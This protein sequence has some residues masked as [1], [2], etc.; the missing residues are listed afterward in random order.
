MIKTTRTTRRRLLRA[1]RD[2]ALVSVGLPLLGI[3]VPIVL[4][5]IEELAAIVFGGRPERLLTPQGAGAHQAGFL[6][7]VSI[8]IPAYRE[9]PEML[10]ETLDA[11]SRLD[12]ANFECIVILKIFCNF[13]AQVPDLDCGSRAPCP[14]TL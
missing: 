1:F 11:V 9:P 7:K 2:G 5:R 4:S 10:V 13:Q 3:L 8:H 6:P 12:Y 14:P